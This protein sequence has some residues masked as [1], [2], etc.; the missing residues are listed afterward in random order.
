MINKKFLGLILLV[1]SANIWAIDGGAVLGGAIGGGAGAAIG[2]ELGGKNGAIIGGAIGGATGAAI[3]SQK[4]TAQPVT[5][6]KQ[7]I[8]YEH[9]SDDEHHDNGRHLGQYKKHKKH[10]K[11]KHHDHEDH[12]D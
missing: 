8:R 2:S 6:V 11:H 4:K 12:D 10:K 5:A 7:N 1:F 9:D 3:G